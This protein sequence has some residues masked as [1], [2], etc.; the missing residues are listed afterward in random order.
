MTKRI[1]SLVLAALTLFALC[2]PAFASGE[3]AVEPA[4]DVAEEGLLRIG[5]TGGP[6]QKRFGLGGRKNVQHGSDGKAPPLSLCPHG[7]HSRQHKFSLSVPPL[8]ILFFLCGLYFYGCG[9]RTGRRPRCSEKIPGN[10]TAPGIFKRT[11]T[12]RNPNHHSRS[13]AVQCGEWD[14]NP[15]DIATTGT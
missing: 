5:G 15:H 9:S 7:G 8:R 4:A 2:A 11:Q 12:A 6:V 1:L 13:R 14:L 10:L 3:P